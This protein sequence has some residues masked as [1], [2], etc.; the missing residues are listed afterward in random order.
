MIMP[1][2]SNYKFHYKLSVAYDGHRY[3]GWQIQSEAHKT[4]QGQLNE[5]FERSTMITD[6]KTIGSGRTD[7]GV[8]AKGQIVLLQCDKNLPNS[9]FI[10]GLNNQLPSDIKVNSVCLVEEDFHPIFRAKSKTYQY[11]ISLKPVAPFFANL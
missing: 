10:K 2:V 5:A 9:V 3:L 1:K 7:S 11:L 6:F 8:H 4:I